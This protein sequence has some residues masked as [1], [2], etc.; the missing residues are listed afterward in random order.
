[1][2]I[3]LLICPVYHAMNHAA[4]AADSRRHEDYHVVTQ[5]MQL[6]SH[7]LL[8]GGL[9]MSSKLWVSCLLFMLCIAAVAYHKQY[10]A[11]MHS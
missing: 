4:P 5:I 2:H 1:M 9:L 8:T 3:Y 11:A 7:E 6:C 10:I